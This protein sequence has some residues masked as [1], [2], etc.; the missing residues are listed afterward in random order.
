MSKLD[1]KALGKA[2]LITGGFLIVVPTLSWLITK[3]NPVVLFGVLVVAMV[4]F[5]YNIVKD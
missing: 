5:L 4:V 3:A 1:V 2:L